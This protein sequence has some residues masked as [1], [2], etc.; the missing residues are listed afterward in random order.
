M[1]NDRLGADTL[2]LQRPF[3]EDGLFI[4]ILDLVEMRTLVW[5]GDKPESDVEVAS[6]L[7]GPYAHEAAL[8]REAFLEALS[9]H[10][11]GI[12]ESICE[13]EEPTLEKI[14]AVIRSVTISG[15]AVPVLCGSAFKNKGV[16]LLLDA[17]CA[18]LPSPSEVAAVQGLRIKSR[19]ITDEVVERLPTSDQ[20][21]S[22][23]AFKIATDTFV[24]Q[25]T[26]LRV[27]SGELKAGGAVWNATQGRRE[28]IG[29][30]LRMHANQR[31]DIQV[32]SAG[33]IVA[34][35]GAKGV[36][37]GDTLCNESAQLLLERIE[38]PEPVIRIAIEPK[39]KA[40]QEKL[41]SSLDRLAVEDPS[42]KVLTDPETGQTLI[43]GMGELHL[44]VIVD[45]LLR[46]FKVGANVGKP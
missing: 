1:V 33:D 18:Y 45:R 36:V 37:T 38:F 11:D 22:A 14:Q 26:Y 2:V 10:D 24:G 9:N 20:P 21:F 25:L 30:L 32:C 5:S 44:E 35:V 7:E 17:I 28:R 12:F 15:K 8:Y 42:F 29:R 43:A 40:D 27:Y 23:L 19:Q 41:N 31:E 34:V 46:E 39:T 4:G 6:A 3:M 16:R 13:G